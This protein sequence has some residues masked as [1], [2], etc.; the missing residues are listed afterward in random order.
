M[1]DPIKEALQRLS[2]DRQAPAKPKPAEPRVIRAEGEVEGG[3]L[4]RGPKAVE[5][6]IHDAWTH[7]W[8]MAETEALENPKRGGESYGLRFAHGDGRHGWACWLNGSYLGGFL[9]ATPRSLVPRKLKAK[10]LK[11]V[12]AH[13]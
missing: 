6:G 3:D 9:Y 13:E 11:E 4:P 7:R 1:P 10:D 2:L 5:K 8:S 12:L